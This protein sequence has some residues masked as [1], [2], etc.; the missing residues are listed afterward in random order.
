MNVLGFWSLILVMLVVALAFVVFPLLKPMRHAGRTREQLNL[1]LYRERLLELEAERDDSDI[2]KQQFETAR[3]ELERHLVEDVAAVEADRHT[4]TFHKSWRL[5]V[6]LA[7]LVSLCALLF[8]HYWGDSRQLATYKQKQAVAAQT[9]KA[10][11]AMGSSQQIIARMQAYLQQHPDSPKGWFLLGRVYYNLNKFT[12]AADAFAKAHQ[13]QPR[14]VEYML[15]YA[16]AL[17]FAHNRQLNQQAQLLVKQVLAQQPK[18]AAAMNLL[19]LNAYSQQQ[20]AQA[21][22]YWEALLPLF[23]ANSPDEQ[24]VLNAIAEAEEKAKTQAQ[25]IKN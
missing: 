13:Q 20:Y 18:N 2:T 10:I 4:Q 12:D 21:I 24:I 16:H 3:H 9:Q 6:V 5:A 11:Q 15:Q 23:A 14:N 25:A 19:A 22:H 1:A 7:V 8:Y 17:F